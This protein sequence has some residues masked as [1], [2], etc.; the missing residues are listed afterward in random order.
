MNHLS[1]GV[2]RSPPKADLMAALQ[3]LGAPN[4]VDTHHHFQPI[5]LSWVR[6]TSDRQVALHTWPEHQLVTVDV[7]AP[8]AVDLAEALAGLGW[9]R[10]E[11]SP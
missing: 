11:E 6:W 2:F 9:T 1:Q 4:G 7:L 5:G 3:A 10:L 8:H